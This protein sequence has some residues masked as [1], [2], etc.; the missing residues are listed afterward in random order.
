MSELPVTW[1][2]ISLDE[3]CT[4]ITDVRA[5]IFARCAPDLGEMPYTKNGATTGIVINNSLEEPFSM[6]PSVTFLKPDRDTLDQRLL[7]RR[8]RPSGPRR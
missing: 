3:V 6:L 2:D 8:T 5:E 4:K 1:A 7:P